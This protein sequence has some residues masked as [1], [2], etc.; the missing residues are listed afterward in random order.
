MYMGIIIGCSRGTVHTYIYMYIGTYTH[1]F[2][3]VYVYTYDFR[4]GQY[5]SMFVCIY[6][7]THISMCMYVYT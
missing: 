1:K 4:V 6:L 3:C 7:C 2:I 5:T